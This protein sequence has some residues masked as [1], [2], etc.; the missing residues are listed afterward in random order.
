MRSNFSAMEENCIV[1]G[2]G[3]PALKCPK[4]LGQGAKGRKGGP[5]EKEACVPIAVSAKGHHL[6]AK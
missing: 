5:V 1:V 3:G 4:R 2:D 6:A